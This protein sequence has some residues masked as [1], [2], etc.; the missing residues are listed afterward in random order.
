[1]P[2][3]SPPSKS[4]SIH[5]LQHFSNRDPGAQA[6]KLPIVLSPLS[7]VGK[8]RERSCDLV[9]GEG[10]VQLGLLGGGFVRMVVKEGFVVGSSDGV[11]GE[12]LK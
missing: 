4:F 5:R 12:V 1:S 9:D 8:D 3:P 7:R 11:R 2:F 6:P 10:G